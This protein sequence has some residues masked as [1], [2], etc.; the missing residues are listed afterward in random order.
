[1]PNK[2]FDGEGAYN[3]LTPIGRWLI[4]TWFSPKLYNTEMIP[5]EGP[6][7]I[8]SNH[9]HIMDQFL[10]IMSTKR[11]IHYLA[12]KECF[13][14]PF[15]WFFKMV[16]CIPV[17]RKNKNPEAK[18]Y[19][20]EILNAGGA[21]GLFPEGTR[22]KTND[23]LLLPLKFGAVSMAQKTG[24]VIV[25]TCVTGDYKF[26]SKNLNTYFGTPFKIAKDMNLEEAN[27]KLAETIQGL[28]HK[29]CAMTGRTMEEELASRCQDQK[30]SK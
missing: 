6:I 15:A 7:I 8:V 24:A 3:F 27:E 2:S 19:A 11:T 26:R 14:G 18:N 4:G 5:A 1:M 22:N 9:K 29:S 23:Q 10:T 17:D 30:K 16:G 12:K 20:M 21:I 28:M 13:E 25:P